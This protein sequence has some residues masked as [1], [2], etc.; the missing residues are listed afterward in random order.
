M[1]PSFQSHHGFS[2]LLSGLTLYLWAIRD[3]FT[4]DTAALQACLNAH[5][6]V[7]LPR[8]LF[9]VSNTLQMKPG[10]ALVGLSQTHS[11]IAPV[12]S[13]FDLPPG[14]SAPLLR[15]SPGA[16]VAVSLTDDVSSQSIMAILIHLPV[17]RPSST[18]NSRSGESIFSIQ[19]S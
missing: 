12:T 14:S 8:G 3:G 13:G 10:A 11:I 4:D 16:P 9:R 6:E 2:F 17:R 18:T 1:R 15:T 5:D 7:F 19:E